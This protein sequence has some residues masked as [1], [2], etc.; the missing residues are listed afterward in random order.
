MSVVSVIDVVNFSLKI[1][2][3]SYQLK[4][5]DE[6]TSDLLR[7]T[8]HVNRNLSEARR[9]RRQ[10]A[11]LIDAEDGAWMDQQIQDCEQALQQVQQLIEP[12]RVATATT[13]SISAKIRVLWVFRDCPRV[14][15]NRDRLD[16]CHQTLESIIHILQT[17]N[18]GVTAPPPSGNRREEPLPSTNDMEMVLNWRSQMRSKKKTTAPMDNGALTPLPSLMPD[19]SKPILSCPVANIL[20]SAEVDQRAPLFSCLSDPSAKVNPPPPYH[21]Y[22][23]PN[24]LYVFGSERI[25]HLSGDVGSSIRY[26]PSREHSACIMKSSQISDPRIPPKIL[27]HCLRKPDQGFRTT[28]GSMATADRPAKAIQSFPRLR[29]RDWLASYA[30]MSGTSNIDG[31]SKRFGRSGL[32]GFFERGFFRK[33]LLQTM[34]RLHDCPKVGTGVLKHATRFRPCHDDAR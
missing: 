19:P 29:G 8:E 32:H 17:R 30:A 24:K 16:T 33:Q 7:T 13:K 5:V 3:V 10:K 14:A 28:I 26:P 11:S 27:E 22:D 25:R 31:D 2:E 6:Q 23:D 21:C 34:Y 15:S 20:P 12:A 4:A 1:L 9:L 18:F